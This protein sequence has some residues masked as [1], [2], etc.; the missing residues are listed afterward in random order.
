[1]KKIFSVAVLWI[2]AISFGQSAWPSVNWNA[3]DN[4][5]SVMNANGITD[6]SGL[7]WNYITN[8]LYCVQ[9]D[10][11]LRI[12]QMDD[13]AMGFS[14]IANKALPEGPEGVTQVNLSAN[15][16][17]TIDENSY[18]IRKFTHNSAFGSMA[19]AKHWD[20]L[21][22]PSPMEDTGNT[23][24]E[25]IVFISDA[26]LDAAGFVSAQTGNL[27]TSVKGMGGLMFIAHQDEGYIWVFDLNPNV[28]NDFLFV[29]KYQTSR[30]ESADLAFDASTGLLYV[31]HN[32][33]GNY[34][35]VT[36]LS[37]E[38]I[39]GERKFVLH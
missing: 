17:Y 24:P 14:Q 21:A 23:G 30:S 19:E 12:L 1:M 31:L 4:L 32:V 18:E 35:E 11:R 7:H 15:E 27:Y 25:G 36:N 2:S 28:N 29:G 22:A 37:T 5:T 3:A 9:G 34:L 8:R 10:G 33:G 6:L 13:S 26:A 20:L 38:V 16:F 39:A